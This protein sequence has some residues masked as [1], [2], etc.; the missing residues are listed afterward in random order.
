MCVRDQEDEDTAAGGG[1]G[2]SNDKY[3][4]KYR[5]CVCEGFKLLD[6]GG[7]TRNLAHMIS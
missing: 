7:S 4:E 2:G 1:G 5:S 6:E 3:D